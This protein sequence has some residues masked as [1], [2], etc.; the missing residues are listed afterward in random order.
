MWYLYK[1]TNQ[2][3]VC[4]GLVFVELTKTVFLFHFQMIG[5]LLIIIGFY[6]RSISV[7]LNLP[8]VGG[9]AGCGIILITISLIGLAGAVKHHQV[10][11]FFVSFSLIPHLI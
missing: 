4:S 8:I 9:I 10:I 6:G 5:I 1:Q 3:A 11:L 7:L 2:L